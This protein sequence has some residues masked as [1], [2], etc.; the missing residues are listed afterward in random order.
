MTVVED[1]WA[2][3]PAPPA[4]GSVRLRRFGD[5]DVFAAMALSQDPYVPLIGTLPP[6]ATAVQAMAW[7]AAQ[8]QRTAQRVGFSFA[9]A[10]RDTDDCVGFAGLWLRQA[11]QGL[12]TAG[13]A[14]LPASRGAGRVG[15]PAG[16]VLAGAHEIGGELRDVVPYV[17]ARPTARP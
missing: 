16:E 8:R 6:R 4:A 13:Y 2:W 5:G 12:A 1:L 17:L 15:Y 10:D 14:V 9:V 3:P 7:V 11:G